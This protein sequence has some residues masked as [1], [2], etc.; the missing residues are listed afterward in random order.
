MSPPSGFCPGTLIV[1]SRGLIPVEDVKIGDPV[2]THANRWRKVTRVFSFT[3]PALTV[4]GHGH[5]GMTV[6]RTT[7]FY[8]RLAIPRWRKTPDNPSRS[9]RLQFLVGRHWATPTHIPELPV[10]EVGGRGV[11]LNEYFWWL[12]GRWL[13]D[14]LLRIRKT[15]SEITI[16][17][18]FHERETLGQ[19]LR[20]YPPTRLRA[21]RGEYRWRDRDVRT[22]VLFETAHS[23][24]ALWLFQ[25]FGKGAQA[26]RVPSWV[27]A[28]PV[29]WRA[30]L[31]RGY[32][33]AD[34]SEDHRK[35]ECSSVSKALA[36]GI[37]LLAESLGYRVAFHLAKA[38]PE[39]PIEGRVVRVRDQYHPVWV[40]DR[41]H[42]YCFADGT[43]SWSLVK[44]VQHVP[45]L[46]LFGLEVSQ[47]ASFVADGLVVHC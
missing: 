6:A 32:M 34:G 8:A 19:Q 22:G 17:C 28:M 26:K 42:E 45:R 41:K 4:K 27:L 46:R 24:L 33:S 39:N 40:K 3:A 16:T 15:S 14:G 2:L 23:G 12:V 25:N 18:G 29:D 30:V 43:H 11:W 13:G 38:R 10:P 1:C 31:L 5:F 35:Q 47:D 20:K 36:I 9:R 44:R 21:A 7:R 37:R